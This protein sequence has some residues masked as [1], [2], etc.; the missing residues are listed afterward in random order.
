MAQI[1][2]KY[3]NYFPTIEMENITPPP[4]KH[5]DCIGIIAPARKVL[6]Q[7]IH[8]AIKFLNGKGFMVKTS[9]HLYASHHQF[10]GTEE[11]RANDFMEMIED[12]SVKA[13][14]CARGGY[15]SIRLLDHMN[16][17]KLQQTPKW[18]VGYSDITVFHGLLNGWYGIES[19]HGPMPFNFPSDGTGNE[20]LEC[21][22]NVLMGE[23]PKY[24]VE[25]NQYN[26][27]GKA[28]GHLIGGNLSILYSL[29]GTDADISPLGKILFIEDLDEY[30]YH[31]DRML[32]NLK[33]CGKLKS[34]AGLI[35]GG[36]TEMKDNHIPFGFT[37]HEIVANVMKEYDIPICFDFPAGHID[38]NL[39]L[40][41]GRRVHLEVNANGAAVTFEKPAI[42]KSFD[43]QEES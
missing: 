27:H 36:L 22:L 39:S 31:I 16:F 40:I 20:S 14:F 11:Q 25:P 1:G 2:S 34:I 43:S 17:R 10:A 42:V 18:V 12:K 6:Q 32:M 8:P 7:E 24:H 29:S 15:G 26:K 5:G 38:R 4:L 33:H 41:M 21:L 35:V 28:V 19:I 3:T 13:I 37:P 9:P 30:L 23:N